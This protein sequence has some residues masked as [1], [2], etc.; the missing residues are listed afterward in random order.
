MAELHVLTL[1]QLQHTYAALRRSY[2]TSY[3]KVHRFNSVLFHTANTVFGSEGVGCTQVCIKRRA[4]STAAYSDTISGMDPAD[5]YKH[6]FAPGIDI[7]NVPFQ[8]N[9]QDLSHSVT[10]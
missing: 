7:V 6:A 8:L 2:D 4:S 9:S 5:I 1:I 10:L 3:I